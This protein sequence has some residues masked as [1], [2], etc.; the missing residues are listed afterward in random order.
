MNDGVMLVARVDSSSSSYFKF[1][2]KIIFSLPELI[3]FPKI[4]KVSSSLL[5]LAGLG[6]LFLVDS[7][8]VKR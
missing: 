8:L 3:D 5:I 1:F 4:L 7:V 6:F 2:S